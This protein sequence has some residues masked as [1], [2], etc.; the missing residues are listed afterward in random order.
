MS[1]APGWTAACCGPS[2]EHRLAPPQNPQ[3]NGTPLGDCRQSPAAQQIERLND[4]IE[5]V[6]QSH[7]FRS[8]GDLETTLHRHAL[9]YNQQLPQSA[10]GSKTP[11][12]A[13]KGWYKLRPELFRKR[14][15]YL[16][17]FDSYIELIATYSEMKE[18][19]LAN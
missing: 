11:L 16:T 9:L 1:R 8:G 3:T 18:C 2:I 12:R 15:Y 19:S 17:E 13:M 10:L 5:E 14:L 7:H 4:C 6:P